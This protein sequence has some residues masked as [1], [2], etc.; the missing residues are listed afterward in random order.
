MSVAS[1]GGRRAVFPP[2]AVAAAR[3]QY[4]SQPASARGQGADAVG[5]GEYSIEEEEA[6]Q[7]R[8]Q[9]HATLQR[10]AQYIRK[11]RLQL[12]PHFS[13]FDKHRQGAIS[14]AQFAR[15]LAT[16]G[17]SGLTHDL[18]TNLSTHYALASD[19]GKVSWKSF[20][21]DVE[22]IA[23]AQTEASHAEQVALSQGATADMQRAFQ[24]AQQERPMQIVQN[25]EAASARQ[26]P[27]LEQHERH[28]AHSPLTA[29]KL[30]HKIQTLCAQKRVVL[31]D[32][33]GDYDSLRKGTVTLQRFR[34]ALDQAGF[35]LSDMEANILVGQYLST[36]DP[37]QV[38]YKRFVQDVSAAF[39]P[40]HAEARPQEEVPAFEPYRLEEHETAP[41]QLSDAERARVDTLLQEYGY[42]VYTRRILV[43]PGFQHHDPIRSGCVTARQFASVLTATFPMVRTS[44]RDLDCLCM[45]YR[46]ADRGV[47]YAAFL[48]DVEERERDA[49][50]YAK[51]LH[52]SHAAAALE[53]TY[54]RTAAPMQPLPRAGPQMV[55][56]MRVLGSRAE[57]E[58]AS[59]AVPPAD[60]VMQRIS[61]S[62]ARTRQSV[63]GLFSDF[64]PLKKGRVSRPQFF[65]ALT[66]AGALRLSAADVHA[67]AE[68][69]PDA[70]LA[71]HVNYR[72]F[73]N[74]LSTVPRF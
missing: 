55:A 58:A 59:N 48:K 26:A 22:Q 8:A 69:Y 16:V 72:A 61:A 36:R 74:D 23:H 25:P 11:T 56:G 67:L 27:F 47:S 32:V 62:L 1:I 50:A 4:A 46:R 2:A 20:I 57:A 51:T 7:A 5:Q 63:E 35:Q 49:S 18:V 68:R 37:S 29:Q 30:L 19:P 12:A 65:R 70:E 10:F 6:A 31:N 3:P 64:D 21:S 73:S 15:V 40:A 42:Q 24:Q 43:R 45:L 9:L 14:Q 54:G 41:A 39:I 44:P 66:Q 60:E 38:E 33:F 13:D 71:D 17:F 52:P 34:R 53:A 28:P